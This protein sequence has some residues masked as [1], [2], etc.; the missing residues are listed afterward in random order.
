MSL[1]KNIGIGKEYFNPFWYADKADWFQSLKDHNLLPT[2]EILKKDVR[3]APGG[4]FIM[5]DENRRMLI[6][7][8]T[9]ESTYYTNT[10]YFFK[11]KKQIEIHCNVSF[12][13]YIHYLHKLY[14]DSKVRYTRSR[15]Y[16]DY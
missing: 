4:S 9:F 15:T 12:R 5:K 10:M 2:K 8:A 16:I 11:D 7:H 1:T 13:P 6:I 3:V 14:P